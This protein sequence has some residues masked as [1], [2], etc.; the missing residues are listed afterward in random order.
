MPRATA[1]G[2]TVGARW[3][4]LQNW[5]KLDGGRYMVYLQ[6]PGGDPNCTIVDKIT[7]SSP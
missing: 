3:Q 1:F 2:W 4:Q 5:T 7:V 6:I